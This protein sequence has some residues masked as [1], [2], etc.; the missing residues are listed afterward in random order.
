MNSPGESA[1]T[2]PKD[3]RIPPFD[4]W[5]YEGISGVIGSG[6][7]AG[8]PVL[9]RFLH[10]PFAGQEHWYVLWLPVQELA[11]SVRDF[12]LE[13]DTVDGPRFNGGGL[14]DYLTTGLDVDW[15]TD[16]DAFREAEVFWPA[17]IG[18]HEF[19][20]QQRSVENEESTVDPRD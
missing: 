11:W 8:Q 9:A 16:P 5:P 2:Y 15:T 3:E 1:P 7:N 14:I 4:L 18:W 19:E 20:D 10:S 12:S 17:S 13:S 6:P